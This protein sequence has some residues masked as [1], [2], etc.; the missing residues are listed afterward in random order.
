V[1]HFLNQ[2]SQT[3]VAVQ[4]PFGASSLNLLNYSGVLLKDLSN[5]ST[6]ILV[7]LHLIRLQRPTPPIH[8]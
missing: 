8:A 5:N 2:H 3:L 7:L 6:Y 1:L 4:D